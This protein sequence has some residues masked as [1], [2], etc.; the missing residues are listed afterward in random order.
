VRELRVWWKN[1]PHGIP[2]SV[3]WITDPF[4]ATLLQADYFSA[5]LASKTFA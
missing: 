4:I 5:G 3:H 1:D 2:G